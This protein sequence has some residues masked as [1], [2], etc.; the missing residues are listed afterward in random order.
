MFACAEV[1]KNVLKKGLEWICGLI[2]LWRERQGSLS[3]F[4]FES[5]MV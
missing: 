5:E 4:S 1:M 2:Q 3:Q